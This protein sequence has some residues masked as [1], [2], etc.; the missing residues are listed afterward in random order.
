M[1]EHV[2]IYTDGACSG[3]PGPCGWGVVLSCNGKE[4]ELFGGVSQTTNNRMELMATIEA[5]RA[6]KRSCGVDL[7]TDSRY[8]CDGIT[9][10]IDVWKSK[11]WRTAARKSV[12]NE[13]LWKSLDE[14][15]LCHDVT[16]HWVKGHSGYDGNER[17]DELARQGI[18][19]MI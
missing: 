7:Y 3:N 19:Q 1:T 10:W 18:E 2:V 8:V 4:K 15:R 11:G 12:K 5:L 9:K 6:L 13:D 17:A 16:W 14:A